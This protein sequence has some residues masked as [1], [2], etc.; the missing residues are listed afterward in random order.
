[1]ASL[2]VDT[3][4]LQRRKEVVMRRSRFAEL[5]ADYDQLEEAVG[6]L[7]ARAETVQRALQ[8]RSTIPPTETIEIERSGSHSAEQRSLRRKIAAAKERLHGFLHKSSLKSARKVCKELLDAGI[9]EAIHNQAEVLHD[10]FQ[11]FSSSGDARKLVSALQSMFMHV[12]QAE[13]LEAMKISLKQSG[14]VD[15]FNGSAIGQLHLIFDSS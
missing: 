6:S 5:S 9:I 3:A 4:R 14:A 2:L 7:D 11:S 15:R 12:L 10:I 13:Q 1:M 8:R